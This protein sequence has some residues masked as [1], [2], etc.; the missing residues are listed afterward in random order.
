[1]R[2]EILFVNFLIV[3]FCL[4][5][6]FDQGVTKLFFF[7]HFHVLNVAYI[8]FFPEISLFE[9]LFN[10]AI[11]IVSSVWDGLYQPSSSVPVC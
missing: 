11:E 8:V 6:H 3:L 10:V 4:F 1:M 9:F 2:V 7:D 5:L